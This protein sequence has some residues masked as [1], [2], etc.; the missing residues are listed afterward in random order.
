MFRHD[1]FLWR[2]II[3]LVKLNVHDDIC[4]FID[5]MDCCVFFFRGEI[6]LCLFCQ[7]GIISYLVIP[8]LGLYPLVW[9]AGERLYS[10]LGSFLFAT[11][12]HSYL[13]L[14]RYQTILVVDHS[15]SSLQVLDT[16]PLQHRVVHCQ[17]DMEAGLIVISTK[18]DN[19]IFFFS[20][21]ACIMDS[22]SRTRIWPDQT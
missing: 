12:N 3:M 15:S 2:R 18:S 22:E 16:L 4:L 9:S 8:S 10:E 17:V 13:Y 5:S 11:R 1:Y 7:R 20:M 19:D 14:L 21:H 6:L